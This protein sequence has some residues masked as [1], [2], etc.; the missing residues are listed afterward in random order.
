MPMVEIDETEL[1]NYRQLA[2]SYNK[3]LRHPKARPLLIDAIAEVNEQVAQ[4]PDRMIRAELAERDRSI[5]EK[6]DK[7]MAG[8][9]ERE[10]T[11]AQ[12]EQVSRL[13]QN[14]AAGRALARKAGYTADGLKSLEDFKAEAGILDYEDAIAAYERRN[15]P[16]TPVAT[17]GN[18]WDFLSVPETELP[19]LKPLFEGNEDAFL[20]KTI[21]STLRDIRQG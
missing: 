12:Q 15:P 16:P 6:L 18:R 4:A 5:N 20:N 9:T 13:E 21:A 2:D 10:E 7:F 3:A 14:L 11:R 19:D 17:G 8:L 1:A